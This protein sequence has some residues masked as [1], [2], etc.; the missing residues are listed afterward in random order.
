[1]ASPTANDEPLLTIGQIATRAGVNTS[2]IRF[3]ERVGVL[4]E[5]ERV[6]GQRR[7]REEVLHRLSI[8]DVAQRAGLTLEEIAPLTGPGNRSAD[9][10]AH[11][12]RLAGD[13]LPHIDALIARAQAVRHWLEV[14]RSCDCESVDVCGLFVDP[15]LLPPA[16]ELDLDVRHV[17]RRAGAA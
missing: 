14:A 15:T 10:S 5:A 7:Y 12:R 4:P 6:A 2:H 11:I 13:R 16:G 17:R 3:Y 1:M 9:A 8:I